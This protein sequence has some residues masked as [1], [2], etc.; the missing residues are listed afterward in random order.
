MVDDGQ[1]MDTGTHIRRVFLNI[2]NVFFF[3]NAIRK[4]KR[5]VRAGSNCIIC[6]GIYR[7]I[8]RTRNRSSDVCRYYYY[9]NKKCLFHLS[10]FLVCFPQLENKRRVVYFG[11]AQYVWHK[12]WTTGEPLN[13][14]RRQHAARTNLVIVLSL[15]LKKRKKNIIGQC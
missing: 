5:R 9:F 8:S 13:C 10:C 7:S 12:S 2:Q 6:N 15:I 11:S 4:N 1:K 14:I 3:V